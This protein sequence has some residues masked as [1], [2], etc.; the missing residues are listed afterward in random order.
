MVPGIGVTEQPFQQLGRVLYE[1]GRWAEMVLDQ[2]LLVR[3]E[4]RTRGKIGKVRRDRRYRVSD[5]TKMISYK[6]DSAACMFQ[7]LLETAASYNYP[8]IPIFRSKNSN[9]MLQ[10]NVFSVRSSIDSPVFQTP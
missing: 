1:G 7:G 10:K 8:W 2:R 4:Y 3:K 6:V 5:K 9:S